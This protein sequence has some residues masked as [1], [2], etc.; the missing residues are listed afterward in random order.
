MNAS[1]LV[2]FIFLAAFA[3]PAFSSKN[4]TLRLDS[5]KTRDDLGKVCEERGFKTGAELGVQRG[6]FSKIVLD[7]WNSV[8]KYYLVDSW[9]HTAGYSD[10][11][12][13]NDAKQ[14]E[15]YRYLT[16]RLNGTP[17]SEWFLLF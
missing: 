8:E 1:F 7:S 17:E 15:I 14:L 4:Y 5:L 16:N 13:V 10:T 6:L 12:N 3:A 2:A 11:A 9:R